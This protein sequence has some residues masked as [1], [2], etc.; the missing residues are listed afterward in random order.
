MGQYSGTVQCVGSVD[1]MR[2]LAR[3]VKLSIQFYVPAWLIPL[4][5]S[6]LERHEAGAGWS[7]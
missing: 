2:M 3:E 5:V 6:S 1:G 7:V 4:S